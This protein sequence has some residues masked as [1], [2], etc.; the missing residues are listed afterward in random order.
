VKRVAIVGAGL[1]GL[2]CGYWLRRRGLDV[3]IFESGNRA[4]G[5]D[6]GAIYLLAPDLFRNT[7][8]L[9][10]DLGLES[11]IVAISPYA[12]QFYKGRVYRHRVASAAGLLS[13]K[14]LNIAD[15]AL[16][17]KMAYLLARH[18][19]E[20]DFHQPGR[21][22]DFD[23]ET[24]AA[25][26]KRELSQNVL[27][28][29][30]GPLISTL[31]FYGSDETSA[32]LYMVLAKHMYNLRMSTLRGGFGR[33]TS[34]L[35]RELQ[36]VRG[37]AIRQVTADGGA[38][39]VNGDRFSDLVVAVPGDAVLQIDG[40]EALLSDDDRRFFRE[41]RYQRVISVRVATERPLDGGCYAVSIP[42]VENLAAATISFHDFI[43]P[44]GVPPGQGLLTISGGGARADAAQLIRDLAKVYSVN[45]AQTEVFDYATGMP[46]FPAGRYHD[47]AQFHRRSRRDG[48]FFCGDYL[49]GPL[50]EGAIATG[51]RA[52]NA[53][54]N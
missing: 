33:L 1:A 29:V 43:D 38:Y 24:V 18:S 16:L 2:S 31:F 45:A 40:L 47:I 32:W 41:C 12:G 50:L 15:K 46:K 8:R 34:Q 22:L 3:T 14:G 27:N 25:F 7:F 6:L 35:L 20:I 21:G 53:I 4:G 48:L 11:D 10:K 49:L 23:K 17:P 44:S 9:I 51:F 42:R 36:V 52:A 26:V 19:S 30:A 39:I 5:R 28:Y 13:F 54:P 37:C